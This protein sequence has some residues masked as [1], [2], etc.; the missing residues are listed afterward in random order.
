MQ[1]FLID[2][3]ILSIF[4]KADALPICVVCSNVSGCPLPREC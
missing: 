2:T 1:G 3:D 4:A